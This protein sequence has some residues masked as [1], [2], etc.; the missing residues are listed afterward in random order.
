LITQRA[1]FFYNQYRTSES[2]PPQRLLMYAQVG[3]Y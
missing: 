2:L 1:I 3:C